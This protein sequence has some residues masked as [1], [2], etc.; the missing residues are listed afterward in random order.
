MSLRAAMARKARSAPSRSPASCAVCALSK[1]A[2][3]SSAESFPASR[4][5]RCAAR[6]SPA[7]I[8]IRPREIARRALVRRRSRN[9]RAS[10]RGDCSAARTID[11]NNTVNAATSRIAAAAT[12]T[13]VSMR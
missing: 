3:G 10:R 9:A 5:K 4:A 11:Q 1:S 6:A 2:S 13:E 8:A 12:I 7:P